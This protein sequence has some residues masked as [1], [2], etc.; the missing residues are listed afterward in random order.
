MNVN[1]EKIFV[2]RYPMAYFKI[3]PLYLPGR[4]ENHEDF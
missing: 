3:L 4:Q 2:K 1:G